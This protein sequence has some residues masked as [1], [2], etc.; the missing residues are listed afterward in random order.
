MKKKVVLNRQKVKAQLLKQDVSLLALSTA[1]GLNLHNL[2][3]PDRLTQYSLAELI[4][5]A[6]QCKVEDLG[7]VIV[8]IVPKSS[9]LEEQ[10]ARLRANIQGG[11]LMVSTVKK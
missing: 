4:A 10:T 5:K 8:P 11:L 2:Y 6:L 3:K 7:E 9:K 1:T